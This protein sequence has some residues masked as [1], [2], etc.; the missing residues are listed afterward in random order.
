MS[1]ST[2]PHNRSGSSGIGDY[3]DLASTRLQRG[4]FALAVEAIRSA[5]SLEPKN[6]YV[7]AFEKQTEELRDLQANGTLTDEQ[8]TDIFDSIPSILE[9]AL[10]L[11]RTS[12]GVTDLSALGR[13]VQDF[14]K[15][16]QERTAALEWLKNQYF[17]HAH[18][19]V[20]KGEYQ[21]ALAEV[22]RVYII[23]SSNAVAKE[24]EKQI[25]QLAQMQSDPSASGRSRAL[26]Q[27]QASVPSH[28]GAGMV[29]PAPGGGGH[30]EP[31]IE[32]IIRLGDHHPADRDRPW[33]C[34]PVL[35]DPRQ[36]APQPRL[37]VDRS[38]PRARRIRRQTCTHGRSEL[39]IF[40]RAR[41]LRRHAGGNA[42][43]LRRD[44][45]G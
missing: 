31:A 2:T 17:Q 33:S 19:Y 3:L 7:L 28:S 5:K 39:R 27:A 25:D 22:R 26:S 43:G 42:G 35:H 36:S 23:D 21:H 13:P 12:S 10:E 40:D 4:E 14:T 1:E 11:S 6:I 38:C 34:D 32:E 20:R 29:V 44:D 30:P 24:L 15:Q 37:R 8:R 45:T 16:S 41:R 9:K 18:E